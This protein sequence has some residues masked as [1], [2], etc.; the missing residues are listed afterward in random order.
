MEQD[1]NYD[2]VFV[3]ISGK[4]KAAQMK[5][6]HDPLTF[7]PLPPLRP[8]RPI[9][10]EPKV[11]TTTVSSR[12][13]RLVLSD[14]GSES[15]SESAGKRRKK[16]DRPIYSFDAHLWI[17]VGLDEIHSPNYS[18]HSMCKCHEPSCFDCHLINICFA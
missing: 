13:S 14:S 15:E 16:S 7:S 3:R 17:I 18:S 6:I 2:D 1:D 4:V 10:A 11:K 9:E 8:L 5:R 12:L